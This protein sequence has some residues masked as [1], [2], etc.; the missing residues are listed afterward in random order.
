MHA[1]L[2][3]R[4]VALTGAGAG[5]G[6]AYAHASAAAGARVLIAD[7]D[8][9]AAQRVATEIA[10]TGGEAIGLAV[11]ISH[12]S[13][14]ERIAEAALNRWGRLDGFVANAAL[15]S[16][17]AVLQQ[18]A[19]TVRRTVAVNVEGMIGTV[20]AAARAMRGAGGI[21][22]ITSG[23]ALG[24][25]RLALYGTTKAAALGLVY[26]LAV[27]LAGT[28]VRVNGLAPRARTGMSAQMGQTGEDKGG[29]P[30]GVAP[31]VVYLLGDDSRHLN[32]QVLRFDG[33]RLAFLRP[34]WIAREA[35]S[36]HW[37]PATVAA[38]V[39][40]PLAEEAE[41]CARGPILRVGDTPRDMI[42]VERADTSKRLGAEGD[43]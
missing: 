15:L 19:D 12:P 31:V 37:D 43:R 26:G 11:D 29:E 39:R 38:A 33:E 41:M 32:G 17:G 34:P 21:V 7:I 9:S 35:T 13:A 8:G 1:V 23:S 14:G 28:S 20:T 3:G 16:P 18:S 4:V 30:E 36:E 10:Q 27:E 5:L 42:H 40:G 2:E 25:E 22:V 6:R 24:A